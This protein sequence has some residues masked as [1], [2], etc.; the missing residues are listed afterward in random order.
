MRNKLDLLQP[1]VQNRVVF[2]V[3][4]ESKL[5]N[6]FPVAQFGNSGYITPYR[7]DRHS[8]DGGT[9]LYIREDIPSK[10]LHVF[11][12]PKEGFF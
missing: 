9:L 8:N 2:F 3:I 7:F 4:S 11:K 6:S 5:D 12:L 1:L 10:T